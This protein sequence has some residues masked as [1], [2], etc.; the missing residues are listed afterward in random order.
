MEKGNENTNLNNSCV[1]GYTCPR[2]GGMCV[3][4]T[5]E[6][7]APDANLTGTGY[8]GLTW[9]V[10]GPGYQGNLGYWGLWSGGYS[11]YNHVF[12][13]YGS[14]LL[15]IGFSGRV[16]V[17][18]AWFAGHGA[19]ISRTTGIR[20]HGYRSGTEIAITDWFTDMDTQYDW[21]GM[22][23]IDVDRI[24]VESIPVNQ[25]GGAYAMD[26][27]TY[28]PIPEP[29]ALVALAVG[30]IPFGASLAMRRRR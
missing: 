24:V 14:T 6:D 19:P 25:G 13:A 18:G 2:G 15:G 1:F 17:G 29:S 12:N 21:F 9:E 20:V 22:N 4:V 27:L 26:D 7:I 16:N 28:E 30:V 8:A 11:G 23:L 10:G 3:V 5:F